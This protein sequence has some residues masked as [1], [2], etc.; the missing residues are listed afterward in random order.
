MRIKLYAMFHRQIDFVFT[1]LKYRY[2]STKP[3]NHKKM[4]A[5]CYIS[6]TNIK[7]RAHPYYFEMNKKIKFKACKTKET[8]VYLKQMRIYL[9]SYNA[10][11]CFLVI[12][13]Q[14]F[15]LNK[16]SSLSFVLS[17]LSLTNSIA[18][19]GVMSARYLRRIHMRSSV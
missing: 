17:S 6:P 12:S 10:E 18:S 1:L 3:K 4:W 5:R 8:A 15:M 9:L 11:V 13:N 7:K 16:N 14:E 19:I 2:N